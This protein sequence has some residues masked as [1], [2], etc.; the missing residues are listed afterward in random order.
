MCGIRSDGWDVIQI[1]ALSLFSELWGNHSDGIILMENIGALKDIVDGVRIW[2]PNSISENRLAAPALVFLERDGG[3]M[4]VM[5]AFPGTSRPGDLA[6]VIENAISFW[7]YTAWLASIPFTRILDELFFRAFEMT[8]I[9]AVAIA[10]LGPQRLSF[11]YWEDAIQVTDA[12]MASAANDSWV[13][14]YV[15]SISNQSETIK[16]GIVGHGGY[17]LLAKALSGRYDTPGYAFNSLQFANSPV[18]IFREWDK[19]INESDEGPI[20]HFRSDITF[21]VFTDN[22]L[23]KSDWHV[24]PTNDTGITR[25]FETPKTSKTFCLMAAGCATTDRYDNL[26][27]RLL[28]SAESFQEMLCQWN[29]TRR[30]DGSRLDCQNAFAWMH[31]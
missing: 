8:L 2:H 22:T 19:K 14:E 7:L 3:P 10:F 24:L 16:S 28:G 6:F 15:K 25:F 21:Q 11:T 18:S 13:D 20:E 23:A 26:C 27:G 31:P 29:R 30:S 12:I 9:E 1:A 17:G 5:L 4:P